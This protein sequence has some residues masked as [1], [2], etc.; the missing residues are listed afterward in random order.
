MKIKRIILGVLSLLLIGIVLYINTKDIHTKGNVQQEDYT[1]VYTNKDTV[2][3]WG[4]G[5]NTGV[6]YRLN[7]GE[8]LVI[9]E[10]KEGWKRVL[11]KGVD[12]WVKQED[13]MKTKE[14]KEY[15]IDIVHERDGYK[16]VKTKGAT[17]HNSKQEV[18]KI[19]K[20]HIELLESYGADMERYLAKYPLQVEIRD[21]K[22]GGSGGEYHYKEDGPSKIVLYAYAE[23]GTITGHILIHEFGHHIGY[24]VGHKNMDFKEFGKHKDLT[25]EDKNNDWANDNREKYAETHTEVYL[26]GYKND[27]ATGN[28]KRDEDRTE[29][30]QW[31][32]RKINER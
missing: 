8:A 7:K 11:Y 2:L 24:H 27:S 20:D 12:G 29:F 32:I 16:N 3:M 14:D 1:E 13:I 9:S 4:R 5:S 15:K 31:E 19:L 25:L 28:F 30:I 23:H 18:D 22:G 21:Y 17:E 10:S 26:V 6:K